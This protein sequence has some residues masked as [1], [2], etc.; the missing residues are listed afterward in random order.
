MFH[1]FDA[2]GMGFKILSEIIGTEASVAISK[3]L[4][5]RVDHNNGTM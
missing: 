5:G 1:K 4:M 3:F 2:L